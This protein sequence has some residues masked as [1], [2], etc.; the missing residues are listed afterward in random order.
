M[1]EIKK[2]KEKLFDHC[3]E[4]TL[5]RI[6]NIEAA[7][8]SIRESINSQGKSS[9]GD[10]HETERSMAQLEQEKLYFQLLEAKKLLQLL[11]SFSRGKMSSIISPGS[12]VITDN[13]NYF[14]SISAGKAVIDNEI[15]FA[16]S[17]AA[18]I[19]IA[20]LEANGKQAFN[21]NGL[22]YRIKKVY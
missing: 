22:E 20:L 14:I 16:V 13:G 15:Y 10:K 12:L 4:Y 3:Q 5:T 6:N 1:D 8:Q 2:I 11:N 18:P 9:A 7:L 19:S 17:P 21:F